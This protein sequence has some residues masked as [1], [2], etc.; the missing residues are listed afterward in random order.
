[1]AG[2]FGGSLG[3]N[4][5]QA[6][7]KLIAV[8]LRKETNKGLLTEGVLIVE[9]QMAMM[10]H[11]VTLIETYTAIFTALNV[12]VR[13]QVYVTACHQPTTLWRQVITW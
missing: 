7:D 13:T 6:H 10:P 4:A 8:T 9:T 1:M 3:S 2:G 12:T 5:S 11:L